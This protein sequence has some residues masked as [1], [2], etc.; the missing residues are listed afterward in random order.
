M[1]K[2]TTKHERAMSHIR[3]IVYET[4]RRCQDGEYE[5][6]SGVAAGQLTIALTKVQD[7]I[8]RE[9]DYAFNPSLTV[10]VS[11]EVKS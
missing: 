5:A 1:P 8:V 9:V 11:A 6:T 2:R 3:E 10:T 7:R 4:L